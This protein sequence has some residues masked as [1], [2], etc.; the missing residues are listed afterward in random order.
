MTAIEQPERLSGSV[1]HVTFHSEQTGFAVLRVKVRE[2]RELAT[3]VGLDFSPHSW[4]L[5]PAIHSG[6]FDWA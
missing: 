4:L 3:V 5:G 6:G 1:E 2:Q